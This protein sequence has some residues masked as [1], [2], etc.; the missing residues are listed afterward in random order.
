MGGRKPLVPDLVSASATRPI[1]TATTTVSRV[2]RAR[3]PRPPGDESQPVHARQRRHLPAADHHQ[4]AARRAASCHRRNGVA[5]NVDR[6]QHGRSRLLQVTDNAD[7]DQGRSSNLNYGAGNVAPNLVIHRSAGTERRALRQ[8]AT[9]VIVDIIGYFTGSN[10]AASAQ[11]RSAVHTR[12]ARRGPATQGRPLPPGTFRDVSR[13]RCRTAT[14]RDVGDVH[15][16][17]NHCQKL[18]RAA[19]YLQV[20]PPAPRPRRLVDRQRHRTWPVPTYGRVISD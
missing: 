2:N 14:K 4:R 3:Q 16:R 9:H 6:R 15:E 13:R 17:E 19:G 11:G 1:L 8:T 10:L 20:T 18:R 7:A 5:M 12:P